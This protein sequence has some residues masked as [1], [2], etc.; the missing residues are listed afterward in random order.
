MTSGAAGQLYGGP[1]YGITNSTDL[2]DCD[3]PGASQLAAQAT[4]LRTIDWS[5]LA[6]DTN[7]S[8][9]LVTSGGGSCPTTGSFVSVTCVTAATNEAGADNLALIYMP[10]PSSLGTITVDLTKLAGTVTAKWV[11]PADGAETTATHGGTTSAATFTPTGNNSVG[12]KDWVLLLQ[13]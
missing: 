8:G 6:P 2:S 1:C 10:D 9:H 4:F 3:T 13:S 7:G 5:S 12:D 11:D